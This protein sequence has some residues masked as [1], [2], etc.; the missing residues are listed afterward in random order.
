MTVKKINWKLSALA[1][2]YVVLGLSL[3]TNFI[4]AGELVSLM[5]ETPK[6]SKSIGT[7][8]IKVEV[9]PCMCNCRVTVPK[10]LFEVTVNRQPK[11]K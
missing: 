6:V 11:T 4:L 8:P 1:I 9:P 3:L 7:A 2:L 5:D 10:Q